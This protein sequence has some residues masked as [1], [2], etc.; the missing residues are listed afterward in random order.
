MYKEDPTR[1]GRFDGVEDVLRSH[2]S[3][4]STPSYE[5]SP[6]QMGNYR[7]SHSGTQHHSLYHRDPNPYFQHIPPF[8]TMGASPAESPLMGFP[9]KRTPSP[10]KN[11]AAVQATSG[12]QT[13]YS[14]SPSMVGNFVPFAG[15]S[16]NDYSYQHLH[17][18]FPFSGTDAHSATAIRC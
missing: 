16:P 3:S 6:V 1:L 11:Q 4:S 9:I 14:S 5:G 10:V 2:N 12:Q 7:H 18:R 17:D 13:G 15:T 8:A